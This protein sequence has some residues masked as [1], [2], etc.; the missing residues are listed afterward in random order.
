MV[1]CTKC[2]SVLFIDFAGNI[3]IGGGEEPN[4]RS[5]I[6][7]EDTSVDEIELGKGDYSEIE[8][9]SVE[10]AMDEA[11]ISSELISEGSW[12]Q[13]SLDAPIEFGEGEVAESNDLGDPKEDIASHQF[14]ASLFAAPQFEVPSKEVNDSET[15]LSNGRYVYQI[16]IEGIDSSSLRRSLL[17]SL[18]DSRLGL[19]NNEIM[20]NISQGQLIIRELNPVKASF[21]MNALKDL[22][23]EIKWQMYAQEFSQP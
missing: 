12:E 11:I 22:P 15:P 16:I 23:L 4:D 5:E 8:R 9:A 14:G 19:V 1:Q 6:D 13:P 2:Q 21:I 3:V 18:R 17:D 10:E 20:E 7:R